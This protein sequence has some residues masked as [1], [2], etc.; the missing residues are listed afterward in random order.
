MFRT[1]I[2]ALALVA[3]VG[4]ATAQDIAPVISPGQAAEGIFHRSVAEGQ[5]RRIR[6]GRS[7]ANAAPTAGQRRA[8]ASLPRFRAELGANEPRVRKLEGLC[9]GAGL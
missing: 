9:A 3:P 6:E 8:C 5:A 1:V 2:I 7:S 4:V